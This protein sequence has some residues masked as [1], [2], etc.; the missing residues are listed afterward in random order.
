MIQ[1][2]VQINAKANL[3]EKPVD[4]KKPQCHI[5]W[6]FYDHHWH[7]IPGSYRKAKAYARP[8]CA[9][10]PD[11]IYLDQSIKSFPTVVRTKWKKVCCHCGKI[12]IES[13]LNTN[14]AIALEY[15]DIE[16]QPLV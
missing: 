1:N 16:D 4:S 11:S 6:W 14:C 7:L 9:E 10:K 12:K 5:F 13:G 8:T 3:M 2:A 15:P